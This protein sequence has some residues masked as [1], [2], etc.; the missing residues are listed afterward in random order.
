MDDDKASLA[1][2][3][4]Q[5]FQVE[6]ATSAA[7]KQAVYEVR[8]RVYCEE[9]EYEPGEN[10]PDKGEYDEYDESSLHCLIRHKSS[11]M[12][13]GC[14]RLVPSIDSELLPFEK[15]CSESVDSAFVKSLEIE[16]SDMAEVSRLAVDGAFRRR[17]GESATRFGEVNTMDCSAA[18]KRTFSLIAIAGFLACA[19]LAELSG[20]TDVFA[21]MEPFL[22]R[23]VKRSGIA[24]QQAGKTIEY[25]GERA[26]YYIKTQSAVE[27]MVPELREL[28]EAIHHQ[29]AKSYRDR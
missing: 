13:A 26:L 22:P 23:L 5:Y 4:L 1:E 29:I 6:L 2:K 3:F 28:Y 18:E 12:T 11:N 9:F 10:F 21:M 14:V 8:Y 25:H 17:P 27:N 20:R 16:R 7:D 24:W 15:Y 19:A